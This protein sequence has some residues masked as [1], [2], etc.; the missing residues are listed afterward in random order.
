MQSVQEI[1][2]NL[3]AEY[4]DIW[5]IVFDYQRPA[6][7][8]LE[9]GIVSHPKG[10]TEQRKL[11]DAYVATIR[12]GA[13]DYQSKVGVRFSL[14]IEEDFIEKALSKPKLFDSEGRYLGVKP[15]SIHAIRISEDLHSVDL[16]FCTLEEAKEKVT[17][18][19]FILF[20]RDDMSDW[21]LLTYLKELRDYYGGEWSRNMVSQL[22]EQGILFYKDSLHDEEGN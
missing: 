15:G 8:S 3:H 16:C 4:A 22:M 5:D 7:E 9:R 14:Y 6:L 21:Q 11:L 17:S 18:D 20:Y 2:K 19:M 12:C 1:Q 10:S 13:I